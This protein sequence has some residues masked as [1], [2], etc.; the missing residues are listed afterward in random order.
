MSA[1]HLT[2]ILPSGP[3]NYQ[4]TYGPAMRQGSME[5][6]DSDARHPAMNV[7]ALRAVRGPRA[8]EVRPRGLG[9]STLSL[10]AAGT[11]SPSEWNVGLTR[12]SRIG[13]TRLPL[14]QPPRAGSGLAAER[15]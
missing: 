10:F 15:R 6:S 4:S 13:H 5:C 9:V 11:N 8:V 3:P 14:V 12:T 2:G 1:P 7:P